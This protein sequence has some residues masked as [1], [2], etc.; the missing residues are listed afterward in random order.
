M[1]PQQAK[2]KYFVYWLIVLISQILATCSFE[3]D[4]PL[5]PRHHSRWGHDRLDGHKEQQTSKHK[6][7]YLNKGRLI[8][9]QILKPSIVAID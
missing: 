9:Y 6:S 7:A 3:C 4:L 5:I 8:P 2:T 1:N